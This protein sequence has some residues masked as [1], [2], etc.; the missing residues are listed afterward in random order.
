MTDRMF[1]PEYWY[2]Q[3]VS[4]FLLKHYDQ[5]LYLLNVSISQDPELADAWYWRGFVLTAMGDK[6]GAEQSI[7]KAIEIN[8]LVNDPYHKRVGPLAEIVVNPVPAARMPE[9]EQQAQMIETNIDISKKP[10]PTGPDMIIKSL[11]PVV[12][13]G[14]TQLEIKSTIAN[15]GYRPSNDFFLT[16]YLSDD[17]QI[18]KND[19]PIGYYLIP[20]IKAGTEMT[21]AGYYPMEQMKPGTNY[22]GAIADQ[23]NEI[24]EVSEDNN[25]YIFPTKVT[26]PDVK[27]P[28]YKITPRYMPLIVEKGVTDSRFAK[29]EADLLITKVTAPDKAFQGG[30]IPVSVSVK[31]QGQK[32][33]GPFRISLYLSPDPTITE[34]DKELGFGD[35]PDLGV[36]MT[37]EGSAQATIPTDQ[38]PGEY[39]IGIMVDSGKSVPESNEANNIQFYEKKIS[40]VPSGSQAA[41][42][43]TEKPQ[44]NTVRIPDLTP[45]VISTDKTGHSGGILNVTTSVL[46]KGAGDAGRFIV[47]LY[48]SKDITLSSDDILL[49]MGEILNLPAGTE[50]KGTASAPIPLNQTPGQ[51]FIGVFIDADKMINESNESNNIGFA[52]VPTTIGQ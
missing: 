4:E 14:S 49:G 6:K 32:D 48:L 43:V 12:R 45:S 46:N 47:D 21:I 51:Y 35:I 8:P 40:I 26:I 17:A 25:K 37:R 33:A 20:D 3:G 52:K 16:F 31:N 7:A 29:N 10:D 38:K 19:T 28:D 24:M 42:Q 44:N 30:T 5:A 2:Q 27:S 11:E 41:T 39:Y 13:E 1:Y 50:S 36:G 23:G 15:Q 22:V 34:S 18:T 9:D